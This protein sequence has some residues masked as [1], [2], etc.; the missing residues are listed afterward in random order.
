MMNAT[1]LSAQPWG[2]S[3]VSTLREL[4]APHAHYSLDSTEHDAARGGAGGLRWR[5]GHVANSTRMSSSIYSV[6]QPTG[7]VTVAFAS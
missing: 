2:S 3:F 7:I 1:L 5:L 6:V 4:A